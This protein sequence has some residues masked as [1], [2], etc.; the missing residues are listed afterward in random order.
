MQF[1]KNVNCALRAKS[2]CLALYGL[3]IA[4]TRSTPDYLVLSRL[5]KMAGAIIGTSTAHAR[6]AFGLPRFVRSCYGNLNLVEGGESAPYMNREIFNDALSMTD[7]EFIQNY[8][9]PNYTLTK[10][11]SDN[12]T[13]LKANI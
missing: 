12:V 4:V 10:K 3:G 13:N 1:Y 5:A 11:Y 6:A 7:S 2:M 8:C 9:N